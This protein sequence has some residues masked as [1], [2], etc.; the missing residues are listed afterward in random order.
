MGTLVCTIELDKQK[1]ITVTVDNADGQILQTVTMDG[2]SITLKVAGQTDT[3]TVVQKADSIVVTVKDFKVDAETITLLSSKT[4]D[5]KSQDTLTVESTKDMTFTSQAKLT[6]SAMQDASLSSSAKINVEATQALA[7]KG[8][9]ASMQ[10]TGGEAKVD[11]LTLKL[12][13][14]TEASMSGL[15]VKVSGQAALDLEAQGMANL[16]ASGVTSVSGAL[17]KLG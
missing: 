15:N 1:G 17:V 8:M 3:S 2:T 12:S 10:A 9:T 6:Q 14:T 5:W 13:G 16:K 11:G 7:M 4:S